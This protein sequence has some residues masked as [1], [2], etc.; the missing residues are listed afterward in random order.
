MAASNY[1]VQTTSTGL[2]Y[3]IETA[4]TGATVQT[5]DSV[6]VKYTAMFLSGSVFD[7]SDS[8][9]YKHKDSNA[10]KRMIAGWEEGLELLSKGSKAVFLIPSSLAYGS[11]G[12]LVVP[13]YT[14]L[15]Y[16]IE[17]VDIKKN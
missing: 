15:L 12:Y 14:P 16:G 1:N 2:R 13:P 7:A 9:K 5:G 6:T 17:V 4:G 11:T 8:F 3:V 10:S